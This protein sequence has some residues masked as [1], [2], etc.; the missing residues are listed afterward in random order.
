MALRL[1]YGGFTN[2]FPEAPGLHDA[3]NN[4]INGSETVVGGEEQD[5]PI[6]WFQYHFVLINMV[7]YLFILL[8]SL[9]PSMSTSPFRGADETEV[10]VLLMRRS[11]SLQKVKHTMRSPAAGVL[12]DEP[13]VAEYLQERHQLLRHQPAATGAAAKLA[14]YFRG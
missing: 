10:K 9:Q 12:R 1:R 13:G 14:N 6:T 4:F 7:F 5:I 3:V 2:N 8:P 11:G